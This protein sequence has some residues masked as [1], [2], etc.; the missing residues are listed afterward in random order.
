MK[1]R[2]LL[3]LVKLAGATSERVSKCPY[4]AVAVLRH[5]AS[6]AKEERA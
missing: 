6:A 1:T 5:L 2:V 3:K 4:V